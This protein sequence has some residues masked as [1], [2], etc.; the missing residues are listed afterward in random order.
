MRSES[1]M[2]RF[3]LRAVLVSAIVSGF[4]LTPPS[5]EARQAGGSLPEAALRGG[6]S[7]VEFG[8][9]SAQAGI[10]FRIQAGTEEIA[11]SVDL[12][13][14]PD[15]E[16]RTRLRA[17]GLTTRGT[18]LTT[19]EGYIAP[20][21]LRELAAVSGV[22]SVTPIRRPLADAFV[23]PAPGIHGA[24]TWQQS[25][26]TGA[27]VKI[28][29]LDRGFS[30][31]AELLGTELPASVQARCYV[32][33]GLLSTD[34]TNCVTPGLTHG[35]AVA[36]SIIDMAPGAALYISNASSPADMAAA[37]TWMTAEGVRIINF[38]QG[39]AVP[40][41]MG[42]G[43]SP[44]AFSRYALVDLA[45]AHGA[46]F[47]ASAGNSGETSWMGP[48]LDADANGWL[49]FAPGVEGDSLDLGVGSE[50]SVAIRWASAASD[51]DLSIWQGKTKLADSSDLQSATR[52]PGE[53]I[54]FTAPSTGTF[55]IRVWHRAGP[56]A[57][58]MR[59]MIQAKEQTALTYRTTAGSLSSPADSAN[60]GMLTVGAVKYTTPS[61]VEPYS[62]RGPTLD[63]RTK[64][65]L[66][67]VDCAPTTIEPVF[68]GTSEAA[69]FVTGAA[70]LVVEA[71]PAATPAQLAGFLRSHATP[72]GS[73]I[74][75]NDTGS[76]LLSLGPSPYGVPTAL[77]FFAPAASGAAGTAF[78]GQ[79]IV[80][81]VDSSGELV[82]AGPGSTLP[83][84]LAL[85]SNPGPGALSC[86]SGP[87]VVAVAGVA[88]FSGCAIDTVGSGYTIRADATG[89]A[90]VDGAPFA[91]AAT[92]SPPTLSLSASSTAIR[93]GTSV[94]FTALATLPGG[95][96]VPVDAVAGT[97]G[98]YGPPGAHTTDA[99]GV[100]SWTA[101]PVVSTD[102]RV[103]TTEPGT[104][105]VEV[106]APVRVKVNAT[107][108]LVSSIASGRTIYRS[109]RITLTETIRPAG[110][111]A[112][113][114]RARFD[115]YQRTAA[116]WIRRRIVY[117]YADAV[118]RARVTLTLPSVGS[119]WIR[120]RAEPTLTNGASTWTSGVRYTVR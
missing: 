15:E 93:Y 105:L 88:R 96:N 34:M 95:A 92:G 91:V 94:A 4:V 48:A 42:D 111:P 6:L 113:R 118:G 29:V 19:I 87:T 47:V 22:R 115:V 109:T 44:Y 14:T 65:D 56:A 16:A 52:D 54:S 73:P 89:L 37:V 106:S 60:P 38:S 110:A 21:R 97:G 64:P 23:G 3:R 46:L 53:L 90:G 51:Y 36:E 11:V 100:A 68:C 116:G 79:P 5:I 57:P 71:N 80:G 26:L 84:T 117:A 59:L 99:S 76:G 101:T 55:E 81:I 108:A 17:A 72:I 24:T 13:S 67:A 104:G 70:A 83:V 78:L 2:I 74:P 120:S 1:A 66:V 49:D 75:N 32:E 112:T 102:Y 62:S 39:A 27:G 9:S 12:G 35:T 28:G 31:F 8:R 103:M 30:G 82:T 63:G 61:I 114:G 20:A 41:G 7:A 86:S 18:W 85:A 69:P 25:G 10:E 77:A 33:I 43:T 45:V 50:I 98:I 40:E 107:A 58:T 119:W